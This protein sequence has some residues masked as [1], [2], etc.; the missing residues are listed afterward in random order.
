MH[1]LQP[2]LGK[3]FFLLSLDIKDGPKIDFVLN[4]NTILLF[5]P[6]CLTLK[7]V[8]FLNF[9]SIQFKMMYP[10]ILV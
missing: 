4:K 6:E 5:Y 8:F 9:M 3:V 2:L 1:S 7:I 10:I